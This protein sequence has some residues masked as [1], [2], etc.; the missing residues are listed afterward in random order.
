MKKTIIITIAA[1]VIALCGSVAIAGAGRDGGGKVVGSGHHE[2]GNRAG[3]N[4]VNRPSGSDHNGS[5]Q[6]TTTVV[7]NTQQSQVG[8]R[9]GDHSR[10]DRAPGY[11]SWGHRPGWGHGP[12]W[13]RGP[14]IGDVVG[15]I[16]IGNAITNWLFPP[17]PDVIIVQQPQP[18]QQQNIVIQPWTA[19]WYDYCNAKYKSFDAKS[20]YYTGYDGQQ[21]FCQ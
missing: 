8:R 11:G 10:G 2:G 9:S 4:H 13:G 12:G 17:K 19:E 3:G 7:V 21:H 15:G 16:V 18:I 5:Q 1:F 14:G 20:G 6:Q